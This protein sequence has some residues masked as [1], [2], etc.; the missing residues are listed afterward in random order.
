MTNM[1]DVARTNLKEGKKKRERL[2]QHYVDPHARLYVEQK[3]AKAI[4]SIRSL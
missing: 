4:Q 2:R 1:I 3:Y